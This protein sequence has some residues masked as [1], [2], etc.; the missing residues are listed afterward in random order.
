MRRHSWAF[1]FPPVLIRVLSASLSRVHSRCSGDVYFLSEFPFILLP[2]LGVPSSG[3]F[4]T[5][6]VFFVYLKRVHVVSAIK[7]F[8]VC[9]Y[10]APLNWYLMPLTC[11]LVG[12]LRDR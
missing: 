3:L 1:L 6:L 8:F 11:G 12:S 2:S 9:V 10:A 4:S 5:C 7:A